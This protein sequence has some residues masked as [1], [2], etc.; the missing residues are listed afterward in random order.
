MGEVYRARD[1]RLD[2]VVAVKILPPAVAANPVRLAR[3]EREART[4]AA[5]AHP[6][7]CTLHDSGS[8]GDYRFFVTEYIDGETLQSRLLRGA[9]PVDH[10]VRYAIEIAEALD[11]AHRRH[12][13]HRDIKPA[14][15][16][17]T[18]TGVKLLDFGLAA[19][20]AVR[21]FELEPGGSDTLSLTAEGTFVGTVRYAAPE[22]LEG[23]AIDARTDLFAFGAVLYE[24]LTGCRPFAGDSTA[25]VIAAILS[26]DP[27]QPTDLRPSISPALDR[28]V[29]RLLAKDPDE[30]WQ[31]AR[32]VLAELKWIQ[33][34]RPIR[35]PAATKRARWFVA[36]FAFLAA[37]LV[38][39][40]WWIVRVE[41]PLSQQPLARFDIEPPPGTTF[42]PTLT[43][44]ALS[45]DGQ[46][47]AF[48][49]SGGGSR[50]L[51]IRDLASGRTQRLDGTEGALAPFWS[52]DSRWLGFDAD[53]KLKKVA[54]TGGLP[55]TISP[56][57]SRFGAAWSV[58]GTIVFHGTL[59]GSLFRVAS[60]GS[61]AAPATQIDASKGEL[62]HNWPNF[63]PDGRH[64]L[65]LSV[66][67]KP[68]V[69]QL[70]LASLDSS[71]RVPLLDDVSNTVYVASGHILFTR[72]GALFA[73]P[74]D[75]SRRVLV[76]DATPLAEQVVRSVFG[77]PNGMSVFSASG[78]GLLAY[79]A[80]RSDP[81]KWLD[82]SCRTIAEL[83]PAGQY[84]S[85]EISPDGTR[86]AVA[87][88]DVATGTSNVWVFDLQRRTGT[89][90]TTGPGSESEPVWSPDGKQLAYYS[91]RLGRFALFSKPS[92]NSAGETQLIDGLMGVED[93]S[94]DGR[95]LAYVSMDPNTQGRVTLLPLSGDPV[96]WTTLP[97]AIG[98]Q[99]GSSLQFSP[100]GRW[101]AYQGRQ[102][103]RSE[104]Y[105]SP[106]PSGTGQWPVSTDGGVAPRW[107][108]DGRELFY[109]AGDGALMAVRISAKG[110]FQSSLPER[111]CASAVSGE[112]GL[113]AGSTPYDVFPDGQQFIVASASQSE[114]AAGPITILVN[115][116]AKLSEP[117]R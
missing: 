49:G 36:I 76:G 85:P 80:L 79:R 81:L 16:M 57:G 43:S 33:H 88:L 69:T 82:R 28:L 4:I 104:I 50:E 60:G 116:P 48:L 93:W 78:N 87:K 110:A 117:A 27:P 10:A 113:A 53:G 98:A 103:G 109:I 23:K 42:V 38:L 21:G 92:D 3:F 91:N 32:D 62:S 7:I 44:I 90:F 5:L 39:I 25:S 29:S 20:D 41:S 13:L 47:L 35:A 95:F 106:F 30:R 70:W 101:I 11:Y 83:G 94:A 115:W 31:T 15:I 102:S 73:Q 71:E 9:L 8:D 97:H 6:R 58:N 56:G 114:A 65:F 34:E 63:L 107:R 2:R 1:A 12:L 22:Q 45:P 84:S 54:L 19:S 96:P 61:T 55:Q 75:A 74:F 52:P 37:A 14:N 100:D 67:A 111:L 17:L 26:Q 112:R 68:P 108:G 59:G 46:H 72:Q 40:A 18:P 64:F 66:N 51:W 86:L 99:L 77:V 24:M 105:V 89:P